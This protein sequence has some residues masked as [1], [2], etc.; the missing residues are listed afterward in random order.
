MPPEQS[1]R[2]AICNG[3]SSEREPLLTRAPKPPNGQDSEGAG[4]LIRSSRII[5]PVLMG[6]AFLAAFDITVVAA[7]YPIM[8][9][10][11]TQN[12]LILAAPNSKVQI[13]SH[14]LLLP[15]SSRTLHSSHCMAAC[16]IYLVEN[17]AFFS[18]MWY[19][20]WVHWHVPLHLV[21]GG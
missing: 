20:C 1:T 15:I 11:L 6:V 12:V 19:L 13:E 14:G 5:L 16:P 17:R 3:D 18:P 7:I 21:S 4:Q 8:Y 9:T 2:N 10:I